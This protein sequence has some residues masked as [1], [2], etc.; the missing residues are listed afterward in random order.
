[1]AD[2]HALHAPQYTHSASIVGKPR[3]L[4]QYHLSCTSSFG[5]GLPALNS[6]KSTDELLK[7]SAKLADKVELG[8]KEDLGWYAIAQK[9]IKKNEIIVYAGE[10]RFVLDSEL[11]PTIFEYALTVAY[12]EDDKKSLV[13]DATKVGN[14]SRFFLHLPSTDA[15]KPE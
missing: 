5:T 4:Q 15:F 13:V 7:D 3:V 10:M 6:G 14:R 8:Y 1:M 9:R 2:L 11:S 12:Y